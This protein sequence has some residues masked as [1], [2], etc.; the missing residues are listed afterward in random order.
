MLSPDQQ[1]AIVYDVDTGGEL[2]RYTAES[3]PPVV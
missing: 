2:E 1:T 3:V